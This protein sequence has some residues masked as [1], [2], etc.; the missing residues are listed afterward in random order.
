MVVIFNNSVKIVEVG[1]IWLVVSLV[2]LQAWNT[3]EENFM[4]CFALLKSRFLCFCKF[5]LIVIAFYFFINLRPLMFISIET[6]QLNQFLNNTG[7]LFKRCLL[8]SF[9]CFTTH[10]LPFIFFSQVFIIYSSTLEENW[11]NW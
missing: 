8:C 6:P 7:T 5:F 1:F 10:F 2:L 3:H 4:A 9:R 11:Q